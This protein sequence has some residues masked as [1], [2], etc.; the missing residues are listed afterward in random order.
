MGSINIGSIHTDI[1][2]NILPIWCLLPLFCARTLIQINQSRCFSQFISHI[3]WSKPHRL[4]ANPP[5]CTAQNEPFH[6]IYI[7]IHLQYVFVCSCLKLCTPG[8]KIDPTQ[9][10]RLGS[11]PRL[12]PLGKQGLG[13]ARRDE[14]HL[15]VRSR[16]T[17][18]GA[19][20]VLCSVDAWVWAWVCTCQVVGTETKVFLVSGYCASRLG[21]P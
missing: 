8:L 21:C 17:D 19:L 6:I 20:H 9:K 12:L 2:D 11:A 5:T 15:R 16:R 7:K 13:A 3:V 10:E 18:L 1:R 4:T 14:E